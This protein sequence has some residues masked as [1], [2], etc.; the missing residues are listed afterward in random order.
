MEMV[1][2]G[3]GGLIVVNFDGLRA[4]QDCCKKGSRIYRSNSR[5]MSMKRGI[6]VV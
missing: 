1:V 5:S 3:Y 6:E 4:I 2:S